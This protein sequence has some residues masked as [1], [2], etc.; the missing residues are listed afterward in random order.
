MR[1]LFVL[2]VL[3]L[4]ILQSYAQETQIRSNKNHLFEEGQSLFVQ[5]K[6]GAAR[7]A[8]E[9][10]LSVADERAANRI[11]A[12]YYIACTAYEL[13]DPNAEEILKN[14]VEKYPYYPMQNRISLNLGQ[15]YFDKKQYQQA[16]MYLAQVD[17]Y[18]LNEKEAERYYFING[19]CLLQEKNYQAAKQNFMRI[20]YSKSYIDDKTYYTAYCDYCLHQYDSALEGFERCKG[21]KY[22]EVA[23]YH[24]IQ[25]YE[26][27][28]NRNKAIQMGKELIARY[29]SNPN[30]ADVYRILGEAS[31]NEKN[32]KDAIT[33][34]TLYAKNAS[35]VQR[36]DMFIL[37]ISLYKANKYAEAI[38]YLSKATTKDD[39]LAENAYFTIGQCALK[40]NDI[41]QA[42]MAFKSAY[43]TGFSK[44]IREEALYNYAIATYRTGSVFGETTKA[45]DTFLNE[46]PLSKHAD[47]IL[48]LLATAYITEGNYAEAL[49]AINSINN[50]N[51]KIVQAKEYVLFRLGV[52]YFNERQYTQAEDYLS[53]SIALN[54]SQSITQQAYLF[55]GE[56]HFRQKEYNKAID[57][58]KTFTT[59]NKNNN[60]AAASKA[61][62]TA[63]YSYFYQ[64]QWDNARQWFS[65]YLA[66]EPDKKSN[67]YYDA[68]NR[69]G[70]CYFYRRDF[71]NAVDAYSKV[72]GSNSTDVD[73]ALYQKAFIKGLQKKYGEEIADLQ[74]LIKKYPNSVYAPKAQYEIGRA[75]VLQNKYSK[76]IEEY[77]TV[78]TNYPQTPIARKAILE[79]GMLYE[80]MGQTDKAIAAYKNVVEKYPGSEQTNVALESIQNLYVDKNDVA[81]YVNY[82]KSL[83]TTTVSNVSASKEDSLSYIA[84]E[85]VYAKKDYKAAAGSW[86]SYLSKF[87][88]N[89]NTQNCI[90]A[91]YYLAESYYETKN[92]NMALSQYRTLAAL[93][94]NQH[95]EQALLRAAEISFSQKQFDAAAEYFGK[96][97]TITASNDTKF[98]AQLGILRC[99]YQTNE[100]EQVVDNATI[101]LNNPNMPDVEREAR[102]CRMK[103]LIALKDDKEA[104]TDMQYLQNDANNAFGAEASFL[105]AEYYYN[106][107]QLDK[108]EE[109]IMA[110]I[111]KKSPYQYW[112]A[113]SFVLL[114]DIYIARKD[115]FQAKQYLLTLKDNYK[116]NDD[117][118]QM[119]NKRLTDIDTRYKETVY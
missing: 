64:E 112:I 44:K 41:Q 3:L 80:N 56:T 19:F 26:Q 103:S 8:F 66:K 73:Y 38:Q 39:E 114:A 6:Y 2:G 82:S 60:T 15:M 87:C 74:R 119:I 75:Y 71:R 57:D 101:L 89:N 95:Q 48:N 50:P 107:N 85:R 97:K 11:D 17:P 90:N 70:D 98:K 9:D 86:E 25:I 52:N 77:N 99:Y 76:A 108:S 84:A 28:G 111:N 106:H 110:F 16:A 12:M 109:A 40:I 67:L 79:T 78:L 22:E 54:N 18:D 118:A 61:F 59:K 42:K 83:G 65:Q 69:I 30:N 37:G 102:Y 115:D 58:L 53:Q 29:P 92:M 7:K 23:L 68:L 27:K 33:Y 51:Q 47:E 113:R 34:L 46:Y 105:L 14:F 5:Q 49:K 31:Y 117:I 10:Y 13:N 100:H 88:K 45:F 4:G 32:Y 63:G 1:K 96:L 94:G 20:N 62:Y 81:S 36:E 21:T 93:E 116:A 72:S 104:L 55:R 43:S 91:T 24:T 35:K